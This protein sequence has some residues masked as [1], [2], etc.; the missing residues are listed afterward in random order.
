[1]RQFWLYFLLQGLQTS[2]LCLQVLLYRQGLNALVSTILMWLLISFEIVDGSFPIMRPIA[3]KE[4]WSAREDCNRRRILADQFSNFLKGEL[5]PQWHFNGNSFVKGKMCIFS[6]SVRLLSLGCTAPSGL[7]CGSDY[8]TRGS[9]PWPRGLSLWV[10]EWAIKKS[11]AHRHCSFWI[12]YAARVAPQRC[13]IL[14]TDKVT[15]LYLITRPEAIP[16]KNLRRIK[17]HHLLCKGK[18]QSRVYGHWN[19][20]F[21][22]TTRWKNTYESCDWIIGLSNCSL[23]QDVSHLYSLQILLYHRI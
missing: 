2:L 3:L 4:R 20:V 15:L 17:F 23:Y 16:V 8:T 14:H 1:M 21:H 5:V 13:P 7:C 19:L 11:N 18:F 12:R 9:A 10:S 6:H 22:L